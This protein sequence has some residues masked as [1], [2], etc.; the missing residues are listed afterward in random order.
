M[1]F[2]VSWW[3][4]SF[5]T[6]FRNRI[7]ALLIL[8]L[9][10]YMPSLKTSGSTFSMSYVIILLIGVTAMCVGTV[11]NIICNSK[12]IIATLKTSADF[13]HWT[14]CW[15]WIKI[16]WIDNSVARKYCVGCPW[17]VEY[18]SS[19]RGKSTIFSNVLAL[20]SESGLVRIICECIGFSFSTVH[21]FMENGRNVR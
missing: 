9:A 15:L 14:L 21:V 20:G 12:R 3:I 17:T 13:V 7:A 11:K 2:V 5:K 18:V 8:E 16:G 10:T 4:R 1:V 6:A 19:F